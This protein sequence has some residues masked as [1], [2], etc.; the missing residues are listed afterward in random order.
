MWVLRLGV[1]SG[2]FENVLLPVCAW[3]AGYAS[4][5]PIVNLCFRVSVMQAFVGLARSCSFRKL[6]YPRPGPRYFCIM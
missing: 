6:F 5:V 2:F 1:F 3:D 4:V